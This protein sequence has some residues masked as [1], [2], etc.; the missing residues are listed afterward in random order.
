MWHFDPQ[1]YGSHLAGLLVRATPC[2][3]GPGRPQNEVADQL[4]RLDDR[5][6]FSDRRIV[7]R[8]MAQCCY[9]AI[10]LLHDFLDE[11]HRISQDIG[12]ATGSYWHGIMHRREPD[13]D[14]AKYWFRR[15]GQHPVFQPLHKALQEID[16]GSQGSHESLAKL[17]SGGQW[18]PFRFVDLCEEVLGSST[19]LEQHCRTIAHLEWQLLFDYCYGRAI[20]RQ[21]SP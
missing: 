3:L 12:T 18:D 1:A 9:A 14:N 2:E 8:D 7:D 17:R 6:L 20:N 16:L 13:F 4:R 15:V 5:G 19:T 10:W 11:S 21:D